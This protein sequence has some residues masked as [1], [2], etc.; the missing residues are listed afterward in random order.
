MPYLKKPRQ[1]WPYQQIVSK[2]V[3]D[4]APIL[5]EAAI[6][7]EDPEYE[8]IVQELHGIEAG[9]FELLHPLP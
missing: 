2:P 4:L 3:E 9:T 8:V 6:A 1:P 5:R 7:Y